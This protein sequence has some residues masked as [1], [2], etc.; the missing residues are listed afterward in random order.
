MMSF[1]A[2]T[3]ALPSIRASVVRLTTRTPTGTA[4]P[5][6]PPIASDAAMPSS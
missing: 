6:V 5:A 1:R 3:F 4:T 2:F